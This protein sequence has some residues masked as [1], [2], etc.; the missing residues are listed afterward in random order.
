MVEEQLCI[1]WEKHWD[2]T[3]GRPYFYSTITGE[4][5][6]YPPDKHGSGG[7]S[8]SAV[9]V[10][11]D[12]DE[13]GAPIIMG[14]LNVPG[15]SM[16][17]GAAGTITRDEARAQW[18]ARVRE[19]FG[20][21]AEKVAACGFAGGDGAAVTA[22]G[23]PSGVMEEETRLQL[24]HGGERCSEA[25][26]MGPEMSSVEAFSLHLERLNKDYVAMAKE[27]RQQSKYRHYQKLVID[28]GKR[29]KCVLCGTMEVADVL[30]PCQHMCTCQ[31]CLH[32]HQIQPGEGCPLCMTVI[33]RI[34]PYTGKEAETYW[35]WCHEVKPPLPAEFGR[36]FATGERLAKRLRTEAAK[37]KKEKQKQQKQQAPAPAPAPAPAAVPAA[38]AAAAAAAGEVIV[39]S[40]AVQQPS[41]QQMKAF[42]TSDS[43][44]GD[45]GEWAA[46]MAAQ[47]AAV[48]KGDTAAQFGDAK[49]DPQCS[50]AA[51]PTGVV[52][53]RS[54]KRVCVIL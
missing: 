6:W 53:K 42:D 15:G 5:Q 23:G 44:E 10:E 24:V 52:V 21:D 18:G 17:R 8:G 50:D 26:Y 29:V 11:D 39:E 48:D 43:D 38:A 41:P 20:G 16:P 9:L 28:K 46:H 37:R 54:G 49:I 40:A 32:E 4:S 34:L 31:S 45:E 47:R 33:R 19:P 7:G 25:A 27:A 2:D 36:R 51:Q 3:A 35:N 12:G 14:H 1:G 22:V 30:F 13:S